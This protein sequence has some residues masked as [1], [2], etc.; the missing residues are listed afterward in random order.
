MNSAT[1]D[2]KD[3]ISAN[4][5]TITITAYPEPD[6]SIRGD[7]FDMSEEEMVELEKKAERNV[8]AWSTIEVK[9]TIRGY[10]SPL[11]AHLGCCSYKDGPDFRK[12]GYF[13]QKAEE[14]IREAYEELQSFGVKDELTQETIQAAIEHSEVSYREEFAW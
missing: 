6:V 1:L 2:T 3:S 5:I 7:L 12:G 11:G 8:W 9:A 4:D 13:E 10:T 14:A